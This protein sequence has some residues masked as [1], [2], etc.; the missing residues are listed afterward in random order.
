MRS[1]SLAAILAVLALG[2]CNRDVTDADVKMVSVGYDPDE[3]GPAPTPLGGI[4]EYDHVDFAAAGLSLGLMGLSGTD[5]VGPQ[6]ADF[7]PPYQGIFGFSYVFDQKLASA[8]S[9]VSIG[10]S[11]PQFEETCY[12]A[13]DPQG[14]IGSFTTVD[15]GDKMRFDS[16]ESEAGFVLNRL[17]ADYPP[18]PR[19]MF[20]YYI[21]FQYYT[22]TP[23]THLVPNP[24]APDDPLEMTPQTYRRANFPFG[25]QVNFTFPGGFARMDQ[26][27]ASIPRP[28]GDIGFQMPDEIGGVLLEWNG[29]RYDAVGT[30]L[31]D[32]PQKRCSEFYEGREDDP[33]LAREACDELLETPEDIDEY[34][35][36]V[37]QMY[38][39]PWDTDHGVVKLTWDPKEHGDLVTLTVRF[40]KPFDKED[41]QYAYEA[42][43]MPNGEYRNAQ[44]CED[45]EFIYDEERYEPDGQLLSSLQGDPFDQTINVVCLLE[46]DGEFE[47]NEDVFARA[48]AHA[49]NYEIGG[50]VFFLS[51]ASL[52]DVA[53]PPAKDRWDQRH[54][55]TP[56]RLLAQ[57]VRIG[58]FWWE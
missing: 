30:E 35:S 54:D 52:E 23:L 15:V 50:V 49:E 8:A 45:G 13:F 39:A 41:G 10:A 48:R 12:T 18:D 44:P 27:V 58:R 40:M 42:V 26:P 16:T 24:E 33:D 31:S 36:F 1:A 51:R 9:L 29:P 38:T 17:P 11:P 19:D 34:D 21:G 20:I 28:S 53:V 4:V 47:L 56:M 55:I 57:S 3:I 7:A 14:P 43:E 25:E 32:G 37:G 2:A 5:A 6:M 22:P 46:D